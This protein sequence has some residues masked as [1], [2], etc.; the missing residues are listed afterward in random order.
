MD[1]FRATY[2]E[3]DVPVAVKVFENSELYGNQ[4]EQEFKDEVVLMKKLN[5]CDYI[6]KFIGAIHTTQVNK[7]MAIVMEFC[8]YGSLL[9]AARENRALF[10]ERMITKALWNVASA[11]NFLHH[12]GFVHRDIKADNALV[13]SL[14][15]SDRIVCKLSDFDTTRA[16]N[17][18]SSFKEHLPIDTTEVYVSPELFNSCGDISTTGDIFA[19]GLLMWSVFSGE[20]PFI[21]ETL[22]GPGAL[23]K[24]VTEGLRPPITGDIPQFFA[25]LMQQCWDGDPSARPKAPE[26]KR[27]LAQYWRRID[28]GAKE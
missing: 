7:E 13:V 18:I 22:E 14:N 17:A 2:T 26:I 3:D 10:D 9:S 15:A 21:H 24:A 27:R 28:E 1:V 12:K 16:V 19:F 6:V 11:I 4:S 23:G 20:D 25:E 8:P 5:F